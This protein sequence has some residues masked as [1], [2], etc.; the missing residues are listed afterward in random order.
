MLVYP[1]SVTE[2]REFV[3]P[4]SPR[5]CWRSKHLWDRLLIAT[6]PG[7]GAAVLPWAPQASLKQQT[8]LPHWGSTLKETSEGLAGVCLIHIFHKVGKKNCILMLW[9]FSSSLMSN[10]G[11]LSAPGELPILQAVATLNQRFYTGFLQ[12]FCIWFLE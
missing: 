3:P 8:G 6:T 2:I 5:N 12:M 1:V 4:D 10:S 7:R 9:R 11:C